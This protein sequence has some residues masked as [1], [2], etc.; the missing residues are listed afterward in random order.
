MAEKAMAPHSS[1]LTQKIAWAEEL[2]RLQSIGSLRVGYDWVT[3]F[4]VFTFT[5]TFHFLALE[6]E[7]AAHSS[8]LAWRIPRSVKPGGLPS[9]GS[10]R[11]GHNWSDLAAVAAG[12]YERREFHVVQNFIPSSDSVSLYSPFLFLLGLIK[13]ISEIVL[14]VA[15][16]ISELIAS[17]GN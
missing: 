6:K 9:V 17:N 3:S 16:S 11:V 7:M 4:S 2:G 10:H 8:V 1:T 5:L 13:V 15:K 14:C 12:F